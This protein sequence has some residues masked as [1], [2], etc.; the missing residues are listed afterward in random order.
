MI[1]DGFWKD[2]NVFVTG[3]TGLLGS[4]LTMA[5][6]EAGANVTG[7]VRDHV[8]RSNLKWS[9]F[10]EA[11]NIVRGP[12][13]DY[14]LVLRAM[15]EYEVE[16]CFHL[17]AQTI[18]GIANRSPLS[19]F[20]TNIKGTWCLLEAARHTP[21]L[22]RI[23]VASSDKAYGEQSELPYREDAPLLGLHPYDASKSCTDILARTYF[24]T[25][26]LP[27]AVSRCGNIYGGGDINFNRLI[28]GTMRS[29][30]YGERPVIRSDGTPLRDYIFV[31][32]AVSAYLTLARALDRGEI[33]GQAFNF[34]PERPV[35]VAELVALMTKVSGKTHIEPDVR[36][37]GRPDGEIYH[38][39]LSC[40]K[41]GKMLGWRPA[42]TLEEGL[43]ETYRW[44]RAFFDEAERKRHEDP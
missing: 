22:R 41:A 13:E 27:V 6:V 11:I 25:Y 40:E 44:Y 7:L 15:N 39:Y 34:A 1:R 5:L 2:R 18:V 8:P 26:G 3:C 36:G 42:H 37:K 43:A 4:W 32:D 23:V 20:E 16:T 35:S 9:G 29:L 14:E 10:D 24:H 19:T 33:R 30:Y 28:P 12:V 38:Q 17:A 31:K 21:T